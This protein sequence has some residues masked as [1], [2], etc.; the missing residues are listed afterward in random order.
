MKKSMIYCNWQQLRKLL[1]MMKITVFLILLSLTQTFA[2]SAL[3]QN[4]RLDLKMNASLEIILEKIEEQTDF[5]FFYRSEEIDVQQKFNVHIENGTVFEL[6]DDIL[7]KASLSY[8]VFDKYIAISSSRNKL[9]GATG[10]TAGQQQKITGK[11]ADA[12]GLPLP[13]VSVVIKGT[14]EGT[15]TDAGGSFFLNGVPSNA[16][17]IFSFVGMK[18]QEI[19]LEGRT[20]LVVSMEEETFGLEEVVAIGYGTQKRANLTGAID[21]INANDIAIRP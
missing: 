10:Q 6:L 20:K 11:V 9:P 8:Q 13:G 3:G 17:L 4:S 15:V 5:H 18:A 12:G 16:T 14:S 21:Q 7:P 1:R 19:P 2:G